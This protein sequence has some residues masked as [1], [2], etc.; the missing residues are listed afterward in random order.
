MRLRL[1]HG[2]LVSAR[3]GSQILAFQLGD[4]LSGADVVAAVHLENCALE[5]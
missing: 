5:R 3:G 2:A 1:I 4:K